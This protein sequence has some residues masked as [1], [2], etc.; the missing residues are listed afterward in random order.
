M[1]INQP[2]WTNKVP[3]DLEFLGTRFEVPKEQWIQVMRIV[4]EQLLELNPSLM[5]ELAENETIKGDK[6]IWLSANSDSLE[7]PHKI[8]DNLYYYGYTGAYDVGRYVDKLLK[9]Y[10][11]SDREFKIICTDGSVLPP[12][13]AYE[14]PLF[15]NPL[16]QGQSISNRELIEI[17]KV[18]SEG[19][20]RRSHAT[21]SLVIISDHTKSLYE[22]KWVD[23]ILHY[24]GM[25]TE[26]DQEIDNAQNRTLSE[27]R[28]NGVNNYLFEVFRRGEYIYQ[29]TIEL[30]G[31]PYDGR[32]LD[33]NKNL[34]RVIIFPLKLKSSEQPIVIS[35]ELIDAK[36]E[37]RRKNNRKL[38]LE[39][40]KKRALTA[41][42]LP[43]RRET[44]TTTYDRNQDVTDYVKEVA[45][46]I[47]QLC[48]NR[49]P[50]I[51]RDGDPFLHV[52]HIIW[53]KRDGP[54]SIDNA[55]ALC[56]NCHAKMHN[57]DLKEDIDKLTQIAKNNL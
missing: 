13:N 45:K 43:N 3:D 28:F 5:R 17:F 56:P 26:G 51:D 1:K 7:S 50:F 34:R 29:G 14:T 24:T 21:N 41:S 53:R 11:I 20:M 12:E 31:S 25:G 35:E 44:K 4:T 55:V 9:E 19:G 33:A 52:H 37:V 6:R 32:Q 30:A 36:N 18:G 39:D 54:D 10:R 27:S 47:C 22:D 2:D 16:K 42:R 49:A 8:N 48:D 23:D 38:S 40:L 15:E 46:G 57:L